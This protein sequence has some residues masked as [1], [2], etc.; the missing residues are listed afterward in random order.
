MGPVL[1]E[2]YPK[3]PFNP[4][5][6]RITELHLHVARDDTLGHDVDVGMWWKSA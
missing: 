2:P 5:D 6:D 4:A 3:N 1:G